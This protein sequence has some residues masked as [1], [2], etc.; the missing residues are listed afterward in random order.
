MRHRFF[1]IVAAA[2]LS[3]VAMRAPAQGIEVPAAVFAP[4]HVEQA[5]TA[6]KESGFTLGKLLDSKLLIL[7]KPPLPLGA[8][9]QLS[10]SPHRSGAPP[11][12]LTPGNTG[13]AVR[14]RW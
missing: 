14:L 2:V 1:V 7:V 10:G 13:I 6:A 3:S 11:E 12:L 5:K 4:L 8:L 9:N